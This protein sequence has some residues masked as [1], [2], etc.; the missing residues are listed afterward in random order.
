MYIKHRIGEIHEDRPV[1]YPQVGEDSSLDP[2]S[3]TP[4]GRA[5]GQQRERVAAGSAM[6]GWAWPCMAAAGPWPWSGSGEDLVAGG[7]HSPVVLTRHLLIP[8]SIP[9]L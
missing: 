2:Q 6:M 3:G 9:G 1:V 5:Q 4:W 8:D 7:G